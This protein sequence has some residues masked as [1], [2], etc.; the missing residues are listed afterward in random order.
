M[1]RVVVLREG[2]RKKGGDCDDFLIPSCEGG[3]IQ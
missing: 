3:G 1:F 2:W